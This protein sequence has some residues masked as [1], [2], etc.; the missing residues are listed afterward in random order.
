MVK[1]PF[2]VRQDPERCEEFFV[3]RKGI[4]D[5]L[6]QSVMSWTH[7]RYMHHWRN[8]VTPDHEAIA[9]L[10]RVLDRELP[11]D[12]NL[13]TSWFSE[14]PQLL[15]DA[16]DNAL[17]AT[18]NYQV[19]DELEGFLAD[20]RSVYTVGVDEDGAYE[21]QF[22]QPPELTASAERATSASTA[23]SQHLRRAWSLAFEREPDP[24]AACDEA[25]R[26]IEAAAK[27]VVTPSDSLATLGKMIAAMRDAKHKW[28]TDSSA[29]DD[30]GAVIAMMDL[31]WKGYKRHGDP[32]QP[33]EASVETAQMLVQ[34]AALLVHWFQAG[35][36]RRV[37]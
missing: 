25:V 20:A 23:A 18:A 37:A 35:H 11:H 16:I 10:E 12:C 4:P 36:I 30:I 28:A 33:A 19:A 6:R 13:L 17:T 26:A 3:L 29:S 31:I 34:S 8:A 22:R 32:N 5:G 24:T 15:L 27:P 1:P 14:D 21:L 7:R 2:S 9:R